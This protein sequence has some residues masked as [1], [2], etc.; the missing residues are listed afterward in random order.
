MAFILRPEPER[1][2][3]RTGD[4]ADRCADEKLEG[5]DPREARRDEKNAD[6]NTGKN[7]DD[8][9]EHPSWEKRPK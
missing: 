5:Q 6:E 2:G 9:A 7:S 1:P 3:Q 4:G 8:R